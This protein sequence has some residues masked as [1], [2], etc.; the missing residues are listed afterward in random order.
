MSFLLL[1]IWGLWHPLLGAAV[2]KFLSRWH[3]KAADKSDLKLGI[4]M[5]NGS[6]RE[7]Q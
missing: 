5:I 1:E 3:I 4:F 6:T 7:S 2:P